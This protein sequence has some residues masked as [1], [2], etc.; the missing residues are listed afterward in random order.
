M[1]CNEPV[2]AS[3]FRDLPGHPEPG[4]AIKIHCGDALRLLQGIPRQSVD[5]IV[6][7]P[8]YNLG[9][10]YEN[11]TSLERYL[12][13]Q[14]DVIARLKACLKET[15][16]VC[17][18][19]GNYVRD[20]EVFPLDV[21]VYPIFKEL[22]FKLRNRVIWRFGHGLHASK[23]LSGRYETLLWFTLGDRYKFNLDDIRVPAKYPGK[24]HFKGKKKGQLSGNPKG[25]NPSD[26]REI[27]R[28]DFESGVFDIPNVKSNHPEKTAH[29][30][31]FPVELVERCVL[32]FTD[33]RDVVL[34]PFSGAGTTGIAAFKRGRLAIL[35]E[36]DAGYAAVARK[37]LE[38]FA[39][40][41]MKTRE[42]GTPIH[43][44]GAKDRLALFPEE[45]R[46]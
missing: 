10:A 44:P 12:A 5:L 36:K 14:K 31:Q 24:K 6:T 22:G 33:E 9:K 43:Q 45:W 8:P 13:W 17:W 38:S 4:Q 16:S 30:C 23:R 11:K 25:K 27:V 37:R 28:S 29:P 34:D 1:D 32:A 39:C 2:E 3:L 26:C 21:Y 35:F 42:I 41:K 15:G 19:V 46:S 20:G 40:G 7:S 18:Q